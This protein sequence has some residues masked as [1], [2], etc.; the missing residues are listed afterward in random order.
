MRFFKKKR[1]AGKRGF[2]IEV[3]GWWILALAVL[4]IMLAGFIILKGKGIGAVEFIKNM[5]RFGR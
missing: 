2:E 3:L 5:F 1:V 4:G